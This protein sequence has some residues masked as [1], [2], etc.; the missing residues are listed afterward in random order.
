MT[1]NPI[2]PTRSWA[3]A[4]G[5]FGLFVSTAV[6]LSAIG[7]AASGRGVSQHDD[8]LQVVH[9]EGSSPD[10]LL[11]RNTGWETVDLRDYKFTEGK[12]AY[13]PGMIDNSRALLE[14][15][16]TRHIYFLSPKMPGSERAKWIEWIG[17]HHPDA[18]LCDEFGLSSDEKV[19]IWNV[20]G[21]YQVV[22]V[23]VP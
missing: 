23:R 22:S 10:Y 8:P 11:V 14:P 20:V 4:I 21:R 7:C 19:T 5:L 3:T 16:M 12:N 2:Y 9:V 1:P 6:V 15:G 13:L 18:L 17:Q